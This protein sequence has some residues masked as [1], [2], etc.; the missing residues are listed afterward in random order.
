L[1]FSYFASSISTF[2]IASWGPKILEDLG[3]SANHAAYVTA[4]NSLCSAAGGLAIMRFTDK[5]GPISISILP[6]TAVPLLLF[7]GLA[8][9]NLLGFLI[10][11]VP[12]SIFLGGSHY[13]VV[14]I[15]GNFYPSAIRAN[16]AGWCSG[17]GKIGSVLGPLIGGYLLAY[18]T[19][20]HL[21]VRLTYAL[22]AICP[23]A[24][25]LAILGVGIIYR[26]SLPG[27]PEWV[28]RVANGR[29]GS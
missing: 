8:P 24:Y 9:I 5:H 15:L 6:L 21:P 28:K 7:A 23:A 16:G 20:T 19:A 4:L 17:V 13:G 18:F 14:S 11:L 22:L 27:A 29:V 12:I 26:G 10:I 3:F 25:G 1:W 2:F